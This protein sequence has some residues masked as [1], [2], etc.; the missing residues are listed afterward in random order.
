MATASYVEHHTWTM[1]YLTCVIKGDNGA[2]NFLM[3]KGVYVPCK[4]VH[5]V[6]CG[7]F[8]HCGFT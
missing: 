3:N 6:T 2:S 4:G 8:L 5:I 7:F 1:Q